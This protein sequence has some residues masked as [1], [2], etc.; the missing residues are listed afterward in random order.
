MDEKETNKLS[1]ERPFE[2]RVFIALGAIRSEVAA[3]DTKIETRFEALETRIDG[4]D[5]R[6]DAIEERLTSLEE[7]VD[8]R[9]LQTQPIWEALQKTI[10]SLDEKFSL[11]ISDLYEIRRNV[12]EHGRWLKE[13][14]RRLNS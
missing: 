5:A 4:L 12:G 9:L 11:V 1:D 6:M 3:L 8:R 14:E 10:V 13:H 7:R 2:E